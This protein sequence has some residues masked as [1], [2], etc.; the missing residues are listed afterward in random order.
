VRSSGRRRVWGFSTHTY[1]R[2]LP[3]VLSLDL[4]SDDDP[5]GLVALVG[6]GTGDLRVVA[7][8]HWQG[9]S[10]IEIAAELRI[11]KRSVSALLRELADEFEQLTD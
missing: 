11:S 4:D 5:G 7:I 8:P 1:R 3:V 9:F 6:A 2:Q 10:P